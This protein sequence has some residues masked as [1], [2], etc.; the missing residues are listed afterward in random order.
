MGARVDDAS[1]KAW[2]NL[3]QNT[4]EEQILLSLISRL[5]W[6]KNIMEERD[7]PNQILLGADNPSFCVMLGLGSWLE[8]WCEQGYFKTSEFLFG[9]NDEDDPDT[10]KRR[11]SKIM[12][13]VLRDPSF[14]AVLELGHEENKVGTHS[15]RKFAADIAAKN[16][17]L[18]DHIDY[19]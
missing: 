18:S 13:E 14:D 19:R 6:S 3:K 5:C 4:V 9:I 12:A 10:I 2:K 11:A 17:A 15:I 8:Y 7:A 1:K 16:G